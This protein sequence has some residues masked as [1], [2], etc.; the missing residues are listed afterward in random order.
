MKALQDAP[1]YSDD[2]EQVVKQYIAMNRQGGTVYA[3]RRTISIA[4]W[5]VQLSL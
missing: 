1:T 2:D 3:F 5:F 4:L